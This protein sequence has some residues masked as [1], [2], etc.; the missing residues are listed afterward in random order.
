MSQRSA[1][2]RQP[3]AI[4]CKIL[5]ALTSLIL[6]PPLA[7]PAP[8]PQETP[9]RIIEQVQK[10]YSRLE[11]LSAE[12]VHIYHA[13]GSRTLQESGSV[14]LQRPRLMRWEYARPEEKLFISDG[15]MVY[16]YVPADRQV[17]R[18][19]IKDVD[20]IRV[21]FVFLLGRQD[22]RQYF[23][24]LELT[25]SESPVQA[26]DYV[27]RLTPEKRH[28]AFA[29]LIVEVVPST[30]ELRRVSILELGGARS[31]F[32]FSGV[33]ENVRV[34]PEQFRFTIPPNVQVLE[35]R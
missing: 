18:A 4:T 33:R 20:D 31:D 1:V 32:L 2:S 24:R 28:A 13:P 9:S 21:S 11:T 19:K 16:F 25:Q 12:F 34:S 8:A 22:I 7:L 17:T 15:K 30:F 26:D 27:L 14:V 10:K 23:S 29:E 3:S 35:E 5:A 6:I